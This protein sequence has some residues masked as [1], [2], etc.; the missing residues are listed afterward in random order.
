MHAGNV[1]ALLSPVVNE[2]E[3]MT[4]LLICKVRFP[5]DLNESLWMSQSK[6]SVCILDVGIYLGP[7]QLIPVRLCL[8]VDLSTTYDKDLVMTFLDHTLISSIYG[9]DHLASLELIVRIPCDDYIGSTWQ[10]PADG[11]IA[12]ATHDNW[13]AHGRPLEVL[14]ISRKSPRKI[15]VFAYGAVLSYGYDTTDDHEYSLLVVNR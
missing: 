4:I 14:E 8:T 9:V 12:L 11:L 10:W 7:V 3:C 1:T 6:V 13:M 5:T 2:G 15:T